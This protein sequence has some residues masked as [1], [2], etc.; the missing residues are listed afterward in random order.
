[1]DPN[2]TAAA[3]L[4][5]CEL[6]VW[7][8]AAGDI[9]C[10][11]SRTESIARHYDMSSFEPDFLL[12][13]SRHIPGELPIESSFQIDANHSLQHFKPIVCYTGDER[14]A[15]AVISGAFMCTPGCWMRRLDLSVYLVH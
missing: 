13:P 1:M 5:R 6:D 14:A 4:T 3:H 7:V 8:Q 9:F 11:L 15:G 12:S 2:E 10:P